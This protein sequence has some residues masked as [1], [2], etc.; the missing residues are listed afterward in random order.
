LRRD[1]AA[2]NA[3]FGINLWVLFAGLI[4]R[5]WLEILNRRLVGLRDGRNS[6]QEG[7]S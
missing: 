7:E 6:G 3:S 5:R 1:N 2:A 4:E